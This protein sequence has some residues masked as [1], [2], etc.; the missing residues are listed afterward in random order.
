MTNLSSKAKVIVYINDVNDNFPKFLQDKYE[1]DFAE[2]VT[3]NTQLVQIEAKD[4]DSGIYGKLRYTQILGNLNSSLNLNPE[5][6]WITIATNSHGFDCETLQDYHFYVEV[7]DEN[8]NSHGNRQTVPILF[9]LTDVNDESPRFEKSLYDFVLT[10]NR[11]KFTTPAFVKA[12]DRDVSSPNNIVNYE[13][14][15]GNYVNHYNLDKSSGQLTINENRNEPEFINEHSDVQILAIRAYDLGVPQ[16]SSIAQ[17]HI[18]TSESRSRNMVFIVPG[19]HPN[20]HQIEKTLAAITGGQVHIQ[21]IRLFDKNI[22]DDN[23]IAT[24]MTYGDFNRDK[25]VFIH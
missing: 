24:D 8:G 20:Q 25:Y 5:T 21:E 9:H 4:S 11:K 17:V 3:A 2:N 18:Y 14:I 15:N 23:L 1:I 7:S 22:S 6:G 13:I 10:E 12:I 16:L 19:H